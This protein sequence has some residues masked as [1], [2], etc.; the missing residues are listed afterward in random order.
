MQVR[1]APDKP[2]AQVRQAPDKPF[3]QV[4]QAPDKPFACTGNLARV[5]PLPGAAHTGPSTEIQKLKPSGHQSTNK[6][7]GLRPRARRHLAQPAYS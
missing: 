1:Q 3:A 7:C 2:F 4:R 5:P 6:G